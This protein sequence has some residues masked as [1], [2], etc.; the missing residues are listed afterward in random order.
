M[1]STNVQG[2]PS[3]FTADFTLLGSVTVVLGTCGGEFGDEIVTVEFV[4]HFSQVVSKGNTGLS[5]SGGVDDRVRVKRED[6]LLKLFQVRVEFESSVTGGEGGHE[7]V[8]TS[9]IG[10]I[11]FQ[12]G[13]DHFERVVVGE[14]NLMYVIEWVRYQ[15]KEM[16]RRVD[17][18]GGGLV[19]ILA[20]FTPEAVEHE[21]GR[22]LASG[23]LDDEVRIEVDVFPLFVLVDIAGFVCRSG[24]P[25]G[26]ASGLLF[27]FE[28]GVDVFGKESDLT[29][30]WREVVDFVNLDESVSE[31]DG[32]LDFGGAPFSS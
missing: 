23:V 19:E 29:S 1:G 4:G 32:F 2:E 9:V 11:L 27:D 7:D 12:V 17:S 21:F 6:A 24:G 10:L 8:D 22:G 26:V 3:D 15:S 13:I 20:K 18:F 28:P 25:G 5:W 14:S 30:F 31:F 16:V